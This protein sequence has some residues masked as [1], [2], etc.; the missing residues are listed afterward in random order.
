MGHWLPFHRSGTITR[1]AIII[2]IKEEKNICGSIH[3]A[4]CLWVLNCAYI[5]V[6]RWK[7]SPLSECFLANC[8][9]CH[10]GWFDRFCVFETRQ[11][12]SGLVSCPLQGFHSGHLKCWLFLAHVAKVTAST[13]SFYHFYQG[14]YL[15][16][17]L[18]HEKG[19]WE[20]LQRAAVSFADAAYS[21]MQNSP[22]I[23]FPQI[24]N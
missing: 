13:K 8:C 23:F 1:Q 6:S 10:C 21:N 11:N 12:R 16:A 18:W 5:S 15:F 17:P 24:K 2:I 20:R 7:R 19:L 22:D 4:D 9:H 3:G 14:F